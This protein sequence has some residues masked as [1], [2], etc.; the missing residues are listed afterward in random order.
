MGGLQRLIEEPAA[1]SL[2]SDTTRGQSPC[3]KP[4]G[5]AGRSQ[6]AGSTYRRSRALLL[7]KSQLQ[8]AGGLRLMA[9]EGN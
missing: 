4:V 9:G 1:A 2:P 7:G 8:L 6:G 3:W 5:P